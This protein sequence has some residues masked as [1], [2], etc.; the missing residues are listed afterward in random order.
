MPFWRS[1]KVP[2]G[3]LFQVLRAF[4]THSQKSMGGASKCPSSW[5]PRPQTLKCRGP[6]S[7]LRSYNRR[8]GPCGVATTRQFGPYGVGKALKEA[9]GAYRPGS[10][11]APLQAQLQLRDT[12]RR[13]D[14]VIQPAYERLRRFVSRR[15]SRE[16]FRL[17]SVHSCLLYYIAICK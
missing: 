17:H 6:A 12:A 11:V 14:V 15:G 4:H 2:R 3:W 16:P 1:G 5:T 7:Q 13:R 10:S 8:R 9:R